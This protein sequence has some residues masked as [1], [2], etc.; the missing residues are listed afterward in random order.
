MLAHARTLCCKTAASAVKCHSCVR[1]NNVQLFHTQFVSSNGCKLVTVADESAISRR[2]CEMCT[3]DELLNYVGDVDSERW[4]PELSSLLTERLVSTHHQSLCSTHPW[5]QENVVAA[6]KQLR[7]AHPLVLQEAMSAIHLHPAYETWMNIV[8]HTCSG[9]SPDQ[10]AGALLS[11]L[12][13]FVDPQSSLVHRLLSEVHRQLPFFGFAALAS[14]SSSLKL[15]PGNNDIFVRLM[16]KRAQ[17]L[18][19]TVKSV[20]ASELLEITTIFSNLR[21]FLSADVKYRLVAWLLHMIKNNKEVLLTPT[22]AG[23]L[24]RLGQIQSFKNYQKLVNI[25]VEACEEYADKFTVSDVVK[26]SILLQNFYGLIH[27]RHH[28]MSALESR[29]LCLLSDDSRLSEVVGLMWSLT[30]FSPQQIILQYYSALH[31]RLICCDY[32]D[33]FTVIN[34]AKILGKMPTVN[35]DLLALVQNFL[36]DHAETVVLHPVMFSWIEGFLVHH[37]FANKNLEKQFNDHLLSYVRN[38]IGVYPRYAKSV[39][40]TYLLPLSD[41]GLPHPVFKSVISS[42][43]QWRESTLLKNSWRFGSLQRSLPSN[44]QLQQ[45]DTVLYQTLCNQLDLVDSLDCLHT[46]ACSLLMHRCQRH[47][48]VTDRVM[49]MFQRFSSELSDNCSAVRISSLFSRLCYYSPPIYDDLVRY[50]MT[51]ADANTEL[52]VFMYIYIFWHKF[53]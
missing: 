33:A 30:R 45:L 52:L 3:A 16:M 5:L 15:L 44:H 53:C 25:V 42:V 43:P 19:S 22:C 26:M 12:N 11:T 1:L 29:A 40:S 14:L 24:F 28:V 27:N 46:V 17:T 38:Y 31:M 41:N 23:A 36:V 10:L 6:N 13:L 51:K 8:E 9:Y 50:V 37:R 2:L 34:I 4:T 47:P 35:T 49:N 32:V 21:R 18:L 39:V 48:V 7:L 20:N